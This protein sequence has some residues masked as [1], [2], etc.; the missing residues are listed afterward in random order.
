[1]E[2]R[3]QRVYSAKEKR[4]EEL[5][6]ENGHEPEVSVTDRQNS[7]EEIGFSGE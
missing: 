1:M 5:T 7:S 6:Y 2:R 4:N 3:V